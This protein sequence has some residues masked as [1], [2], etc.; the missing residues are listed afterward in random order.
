MSKFSSTL[1]LTDFDD[2]ITPS[3]ECVKPVTLKNQKQLSVGI[4]GKTLKKVEVISIYFMY[5]I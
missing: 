4:K 3:Q 5:Y 1:Q 2:F